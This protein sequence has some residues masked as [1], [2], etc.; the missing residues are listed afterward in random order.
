MHD[1]Q[2]SPRSNFLS[3]IINRGSQHQGKDHLIIALL[4]SSRPSSLA[5]QKYKQLPPLHSYSYILHLI[6]YSLISDFRS[7]LSVRE[8]FQEI[9]PQTR[10]TCCVAVI[11]VTSFR[12]LLFP[13]TLPLSVFQV[14]CTSSFFHHRNSLAPSVGS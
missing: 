6:V 7:N 14:P 2:P 5:F 3:I 11:Q 9:T 1:N 13:K 12:E 8:V 4:K 10:L